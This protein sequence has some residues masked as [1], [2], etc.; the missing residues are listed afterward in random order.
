MA[1]SEAVKPAA[2]EG[3]GRYNRSSAVQAAGLSPAVPMLEQA[4]RAVSLPGGR[5]PIVIGDYG[6]SQGHNSLEPLGAAIDVLRKRVGDE[7][8]ICVV[9][10]DQP[11]NDFTALFETLRDDPQSYLKRDAAVFALAVGRSFYEQVLPAETVSLGWS[12]WAVQWLSRAPMAIPDQVQVA[13]SGDAAVREAFH[14][15][16]AEDWR[17][18]LVARGRELCKGG[19]L[20][21]LT[22]AVD[23]R[24]EF[25]YRA[26]LEAMYGSL[27]EMAQSGF[28]EEKELRRMV[29][30]TVGRSREEFLAPFGT[31]GSFAGLRVEEAQVFLGDDHI[32]ADFERDGDAGTFGARWAAFSRASVFPTLAEGLENSHDAARL[33]AFMTQLERMTAAR[34]AERPERMLIPLARVHL[35][36]C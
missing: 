15:Q 21:V 29:I 12:S 31:A 34:L 5:L 35:F 32:W 20:V 17:R 2:M 19:H 9:H 8:A 18:F 10:V 7:R 1:G 11:G 22:M 14:Q 25:G 33:E 6:S 36:S 23:E 30:P 3:Q 28:M 16:A 26:L 4:A 13:A 24:G 27:A